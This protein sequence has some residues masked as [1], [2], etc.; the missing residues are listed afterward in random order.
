MTDKRPYDEYAA[1]FHAQLT[2]ASAAAPRQAPRPR[3]RWVYAGAAAL[4]AGA[5]VALTGIIP[6]GETVNPVGTPDARAVERL[7]RSLDRGVLEYRLE[8]R[9]RDAGPWTTH[10]QTEWHD[11]ERPPVRYVRSEGAGPTEQTWYTGPKDEYVLVGTSTGLSVVEHKDW[12]NTGI[13]IGAESPATELR[14]LVR[15]VQTGR[16]ERDTVTSRRSG[17]FLIVTRRSPPGQAT[18]D[19]ATFEET[20]AGSK[21][22]PGTVPARLITRYWLRT[23]KHARIERVQEGLEGKAFKGGQQLDYESRTTRWVVHPRI[24]ATLSKVDLPDFKRLGYRVRE[25]DC[26]SPGNRPSGAPLPGPC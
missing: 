10:V 12:S 2:E 25:L 17:P 23:G 14:R 16:S 15:E 24:P 4:A 22:D 3:R 18:P 21:S 20:L 19:G 5:A 1:A 13:R 8:V 7:V 26:A 9:T 11:L 6:G